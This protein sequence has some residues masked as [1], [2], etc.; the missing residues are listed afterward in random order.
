I[1]DELLAVLAHLVA[2]A[3]LLR[4]LAERYLGK[5]TLDGLHQKLPAA[6]LLRLL[7]L[8]RLLPW[9]WLL[10]IRLLRKRRCAEGDRRNRHRNAE[11]RVHDR[12][13]LHGKRPVQATCH[14]EAFPAWPAL[15]ALGRY[16][17]MPRGGTGAW[18]H[19]LRRRRERA[20]RT[21]HR[22]TGC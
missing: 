7:A 2:F 20:P 16:P 15:R 17:K 6:Q 9:L 13:S 10:L 19:P 4:E 18:M 1:L 3:F 14:G 21:F 22:S 8:L 5:V 11:S 12:S